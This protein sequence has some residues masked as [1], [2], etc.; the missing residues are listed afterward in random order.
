MA[1]DHSPRPTNHHTSLITTMISAEAE[2][3][4]CLLSISNQ[5]NGFSVPDSNV[6]RETE[7]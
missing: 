6:V 5:F 1:A 4:I 7:V 3:R 2:M